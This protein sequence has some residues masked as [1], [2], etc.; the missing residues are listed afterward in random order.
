MYGSTTEGDV[1]KKPGC[2]LVYGSTTK[3]GVVKSSGENRGKNT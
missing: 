1:V 3:G 2:M